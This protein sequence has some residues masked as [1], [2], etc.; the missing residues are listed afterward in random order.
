MTI[1]FDAVLIEYIVRKT[2]RE[3]NQRNHQGEAA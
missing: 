1:S 3:A 2:E